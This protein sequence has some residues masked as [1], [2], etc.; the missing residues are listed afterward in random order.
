MIQCQ[1]RRNNLT[2]MGDSVFPKLLS[3]L[4]FLALIFWSEGADA[5]S[6]A[7]LASQESS[8]LFS[9]LLLLIS[10]MVVMFMAAGFCML[11]AGMVRSKNVAT[12]C[13]KNITLYSVSGIMFFLLGYNLMFAG[14]DG[15][16]F[17]TPFWWGPEDAA[18][19]SE[20]PDFAAGYASAAIWFFQMVFVAT[21]ASIVSGTIAERVRI[22]P[23]LIFTA[24]LA[25]VIYPIIGSWV[26]GGGWLAEMGFSDF[27]G[28][29]VVHSTG[30]WAAL[31]GAIFIG[32]RRG[33]YGKGGEIHPLPASSV[34]LAALGTFILWL[35]WFGFNGG[36]QLAFGSAGDAAAVAQIFANTNMAAAGGVITA[37]LLTRAFYG[38]ID[39]T[40]VLNGAIGGLVAIT[41]APL[42]PTL[43]EALTIGAVGG[44]LVV[45][46]VPLLDRFKIDDVVGAISAHLIAGIWGTLIVPWTNA[47]ASF[48]V[49]LQGV[50]A[51]G[52]FVSFCSALVWAALKVSMGLRIDE[53]DERNGT[54]L[55]EL[56]IEAYPEFASGAESS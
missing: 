26:W 24:F 46:F 16:F 30:G 27:A 12:I 45:L 34:P 18:A 48:L 56:G 20:K 52:L 53:E 3:L 32:A 33:K 19:L 39:I 10:G 8:F 9:T 5:A 4:G 43:G 11:E 40:L 51:I 17:G 41:A 44:A 49:Q 29:T 13:L 14:V 55:S 7:Q 22:F 42:T 6:R 25:G 15:G 35:G 54:D 47:D 23:F 21:A 28:S 2:Q 31:M 1:T 36:S 38:K 50:L 37:M